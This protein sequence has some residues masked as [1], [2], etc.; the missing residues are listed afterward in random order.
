MANRLSDRKQVHDHDGDA[1][2]SITSQTPAEVR[3][4]N[5]IIAVGSRESV[6]AQP[7]GALPLLVG[8]QDTGP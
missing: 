2:A 1:R 4:A 3:R 5:G 7:K 8:P 6:V